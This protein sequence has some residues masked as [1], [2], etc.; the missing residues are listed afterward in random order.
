M[1]YLC[2][3]FVVCVLGEPMCN[4]VPGQQ[5]DIAESFFNAPISEMQWIGAP[6]S[7]KPAFANLLCLGDDYLLVYVVTN[8]GMLFRSVDGGKHFLSQQSFLDGATRG[9]RVT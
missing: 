7:Q 1:L 4:S 9:V 5:V 2:A 6:D 8:D 3:L